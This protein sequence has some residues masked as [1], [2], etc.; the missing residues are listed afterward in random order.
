MDFKSLEAGKTTNSFRDYASSKVG[1]WFLAVEGAQRWGKYGIISVVQ[2]PGNLYTHIWDP[3]PWLLMMFVKWMLYP[4][5]FG[6]YTMLFA[7][8]SEEIGLEK[9]NGTYIEPFGR[10]MRNSRRDIY[11]AMAAGRAT[12]FWEWCEKVYAQYT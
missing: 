12:E 7:A 2:N 4:P 8:F 1:N 6:G 9:N 10:V 5:R 11:D 3:Q